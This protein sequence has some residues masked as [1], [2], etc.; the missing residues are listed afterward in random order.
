MNRG[1]RFRD[2][3]YVTIYQTRG[4]KAL[5]ITTKIFTPLRA[6]TNFEHSVRRIFFKK[7]K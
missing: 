2:D 3:I 7:H 4:Y 1:G 6:S 5:K